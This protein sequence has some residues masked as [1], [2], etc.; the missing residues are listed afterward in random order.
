[1]P[2]LVKLFLLHT[3]LR[4][5][6]TLGSPQKSTG[7]D[8]FK[9]GRWDEAVA[10]YT[11]CLALDPLDENAAYNAKL[12]CNRCVVVSVCIR[13]RALSQMQRSLS[14]TDGGV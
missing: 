5:H 8:A 3:L 10:S 6:A 14:A 7:N 2:L 12:Y 11:E 4:V 1:M 9:A 13:E